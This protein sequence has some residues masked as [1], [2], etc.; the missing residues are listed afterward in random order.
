VVGAPHR[1]LRENG[2]PGW[3][4]A[5]D[6]LPRQ[7][8]AYCAEEQRFGK[9]HSPH[10]SRS[11]AFRELLAATRGWQSRLE[12]DLSDAGRGAVEFSD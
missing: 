7:K 11:L 2:T 1:R 4:A 3:A 5:T 8:V 10:G 9:G 6:S 12:I